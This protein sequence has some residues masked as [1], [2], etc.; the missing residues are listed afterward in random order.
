MAE[1]GTEKATP[2]KKDDA[3]K[4]GQVAQ[5]PDL[6]GSVVLLSALLA[7]SVTAPWI[8][9]KMVTATTEVLDL[10]RTPGWWTARASD[11]CSPTSSPPS[12]WPCSRSRRRARSPA[13][14][15]ACAGRPQAVARALKP[16]PKRLNPIS[17]AKSIFGPRCTSRRQERR[18]GRRGRRDRRAGALPRARRARALVGMPLELLALV[19]RCRSAIAQRPRSPTW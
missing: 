13:W 15:R 4:K 8:W 17:G 9:G 7:L 11:P 6:N 19:A 14:S 10:I 2:K 16:D 1:E 12:A 5:S 18:E 3:R